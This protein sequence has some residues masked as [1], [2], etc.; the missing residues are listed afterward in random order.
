MCKDSQINS[1]VHLEFYSLL[2]NF[3][4]KNLKHPVVI[5]KSLLL[6]H[7]YLNR[8]NKKAL[9]VFNTQN[10]EQNMI[11]TITLKLQE[12][13]LNYWNSIVYDYSEFIRR[14]FLLNFKY[15][16]VVENNFSVSKMDFVYKILSF[17]NPELIKDLFEFFGFL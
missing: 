11:E 13:Y 14:K 7:S 10:E 3:I 2:Y 9:I 15:I 17:Q 6:L 1:Q 12:S 8:T 4:I 16:K 5:F